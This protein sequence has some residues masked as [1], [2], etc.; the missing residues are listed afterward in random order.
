MYNVGKCLLSDK[1]QQARMSQQELAN[2]LD[3]RRQQ[4]NHYVSGRRV[5]NLQI[6]KNIAAALN[7][8]IEDLY[9]WELVEERDKRR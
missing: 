3:V 9:E 8:N 1:L 4:I 6:A 2:I 5:M 7:C